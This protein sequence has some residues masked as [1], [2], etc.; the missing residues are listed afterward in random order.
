MTK[1]MASP[2]MSKVS[3]QMTDTNLP[4]AEGGI[5]FDDFTAKTF[6]K[7]VRRVSATAKA[8]MEQ[9]A[10]QEQQ[11]QG[12]GQEDY[13]CEDDVPAP[14]AKRRKCNEPKDKR[15]GCGQSGLQVLHTE[16]CKELKCRVAWGGLRHTRGGQP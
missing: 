5:S 3:M 6:N 12:G 1:W 2:T 4:L 14:A 10:Q 15:G 13:D 8:F 7:G 9:K 16:V 11:P